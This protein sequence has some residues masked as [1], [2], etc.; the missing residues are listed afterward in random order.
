MKKLLVLIAL[1]PLHAFADV[2]AIEG[3]FLLTSRMCEGGKKHPYPL[4]AADELVY[5]FDGRG[6]WYETHT[7]IG[8]DGVKRDGGVT[9]FYQIN[10]TEVAL[11]TV[12]MLLPGIGW[13]TV[14]GSSEDNTTY[15]QANIKPKQIVLAT[16]STD[17]PGSRELLVL[18]RGL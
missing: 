17:C 9:G 13:T 4:T 7:L 18:G 16:E 11:E 14:A 12:Q 6:A 8:K 10:G 2:S 15:Y 1:L 3:T 5:V